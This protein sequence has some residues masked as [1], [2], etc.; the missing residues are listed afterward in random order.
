DG[1]AVLRTT[2]I[3][4]SGRV[5]TARCPRIQLSENEFARYRVERGDLL[6]TRTGSL[7]TLALFDDDV[8][9]IPGAYLIQFRLAAPDITRRFVYLFLRSPIGQRALLGGGAGVGRPNLNAPTIE[10]IPI[11]L[12]PLEEQPAIVEAIESAM[13]SL[14]ALAPELERC[15]QLMTAQRQSILKAAF[16]GQLVPQDP[17]DEPASALLARL[18]A[19]ASA[20][21]P[22]PKRRGRPP[23]QAAVTV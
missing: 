8:E 14:E 4:D 11:P 7:G 10:A 1:Y 21:S 15:R 12:P 17:R 22:A 18:A 13:T 23:R 6:V 5:D 9:A 3:S 20:A 16:S 19:Q 2:D